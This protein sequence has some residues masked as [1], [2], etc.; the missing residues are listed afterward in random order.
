MLGIRWIREEHVEV[1][2]A[3]KEVYGLKLLSPTEEYADLTQNTDR[4]RSLILRMREFH[5]RASIF[6]LAVKRTRVKDFPA[7]EPVY[8]TSVYLFTFL[9]TLW[10]ELSSLGFVKMD[11]W[12]TANALFQCQTLTDEIY[13]DAEKRISTPKGIPVFARGV[14][15]QPPEDRSYS[16]FVKG[17]IEKKKARCVY[18]FLKVFKASAVYPGTFNLETLFSLE[19]TGVFWFRFNLNNLLPLIKAKKRFYSSQFEIQGW[20]EIEAAYADGSL[21]LA[22][23]E[24]TFITDQEK[25]PVERLFGS[26]GFNFLEWYSGFRSWIYDTPLYTIET[27]CSFFLDHERIASLL[28][29]SFA[30]N[31]QKSDADTIYGISKKKELVVYSAFEEAQSPHKLFVAPTRSGKSFLTQKLVVEVMGIDPEKLWTGEGLPED[32]KLPV[33]V[34]YFDV[35]FSAEFLVRLMKERGYSVEIISPH[36]D[37]RLNPFELDGRE[38]VD[39]VVGFVNMLLG[40]K[41][42]RGLESE[43]D[44]AFRGFLEYFVDNLDAFRELWE[45]EELS[46]FRTAD[47]S[48]YEEAKRLG[49]DDKTP[50]RELKKH[51]KRL[52][53]PRIVDVISVLKGFIQELP[54]SE[55]GKKKALLGVR[56]KLKMISQ[57]NQFRYW[58]SFELPDRDFIYLDLAYIKEHSLFVPIY[59]AILYKVFKTLKKEKIDRHKFVIN[60]EFHNVST[61]PTFAKAYEKLIREA[62]KFNV[63]LWLITQEPTDFP[64]ALVNNI[65]TKVILRPA[66]ELGGAKEGAFIRSVLEHFSLDLPESAF[67][68]PR[69][70]PLFVYPSGWFTMRAPLSEVEFTLYESRKITEIETPD[71]IRIKKTYVAEE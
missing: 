44:F 38:D 41:G 16:Y 47:P 54:E 13:F 19:W 63:H 5:S 55:K 8:R 40:V 22:E 62:A 11:G 14:Y 67:D 52:S 18:P 59:S 2:R 20:N 29:L 7:K 42:E 45:E 33:K 51:F 26:L 15:F 60:D 69:Y 64:K 25:P 3:P 43:E 30:K 49:Y 9:K 61:V 58:S 50:V 32:K 4:I 24:P 28:P 21:V 31:T 39:S 71:G 37:I 57:I 53:Y 48:L 46:F 6:T 1:N 10:E 65:G 23:V 70:T 35:G 27:T 56:E 66:G 17:E 12:E 34:V 68:L 36:A